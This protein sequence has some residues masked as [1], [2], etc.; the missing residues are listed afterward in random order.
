[1]CPP[2]QF[3]V[4]RWRGRIHQ[5]E[6]YRPLGRSLEQK[7]FLMSWFM[8]MAWQRSIASTG[9]FVVEGRSPAHVQRGSDHYDHQDDRPDRW[10]LMSAAVL[11]AEVFFL[12]DDL[13]PWLL[14]AFGAAMVVGNLAAFVR[15][16]RPSEEATERTPRPLLGRSLV[17]ILIGS[18][19]SVWALASLL[20]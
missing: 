9:E 2:L 1:M 12:G 5:H 11:A 16:P 17:F 8:T 13:L 18:V 6:K 7:F 19:A 4:L 10:T 14:L 3:L 20:R 15:P